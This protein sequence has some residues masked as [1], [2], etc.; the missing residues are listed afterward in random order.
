[1]TFDFLSTE[2]A[3]QVHAQ[4]LSRF[5]GAEGLRD[6]SLLESAL[7]QPQASFGGKYLYGTVYEMAAAY[8]FHI[9]SNHPFIDGN[10]RGG[11][12]CAIIFLEING[13]EVD[14]PNGSLYDLTYG[15]AE[16]KIEKAE[17]AKHLEALSKLSK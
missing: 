12:L 1:M 13:I 8:L 16:G 3:L 17:I 14:D 15:V 5:G 4:Q 2:D 10:K 11:L 9:V 7:A 6:K